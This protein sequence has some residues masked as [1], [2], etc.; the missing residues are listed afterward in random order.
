EMKV[1]SVGEIAAAASIMPRQFAAYFEIPTDSDPAALVSAIKKA[2]ACAK[3]RTGGVT[4]SAFPEPA[5]VARFMMRCRDA[6][7][8]FKLTAGLHHPIRAEYRLTYADDAPRGTMFGYI[9]MFCAAVLAWKGADESV[10]L[11][12]LLA[13]S[14]RDFQFTDES[15]SFGERVVSIASIQGAREKFV[16]SFGSCSF[17]EP[18][19]E[20]A[21]LSTS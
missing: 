11:S 13:T 7:V 15:L 8:A 10:I 21:A 1:S 2:G 14:L 6:G 17:R 5:A 16:I 9:N 12:A 3:M 18:V 4:E 19:D 20:L